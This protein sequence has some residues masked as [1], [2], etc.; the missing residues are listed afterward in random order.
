MIEQRQ[1]IYRT[2]NRAVVIF[3]DEKMNESNIYYIDSDFIIIIDS[4]LI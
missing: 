4:S 2:I 3:G 1:I